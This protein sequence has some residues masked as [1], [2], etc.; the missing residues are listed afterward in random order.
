MPNGEHERHTGVI[1]SLYPDGNG[2]LI[3]PDRLNFDSLQFRVD[4]LQTTGVQRIDRFSEV[5]FYARKASKNAKNQ[6]DIARCITRRNG[7]LITAERRERG[8]DR[9]RLGAMYLPN[10]TK[11]RI[12]NEY[13]LNRELGYILD[14]NPNTLFGFILPFNSPHN[15][16]FVHIDDC[17]IFGKRI[18]RRYMEVEFVRIKDDTNEREKALHVSGKN[19]TILRPISE[20]HYLTGELT[21]NKLEL[22]DS[23]N[24]DLPRHKGQIVRVPSPI[25]TPQT[26]IIIKPNDMGYEPVIGFMGAVKSLNRK[27]LR[28]FDEVE[29]SVATNDKN[30]DENNN[31]LL[32]AYNITAGGNKPIIGAIRDLGRYLNSKINGETEL[33]KLDE[34]DI[35]QNGT[36]IKGFIASYNKFRKSGTIEIE[37]LQN[38]KRYRKCLFDIKDANLDSDTDTEIS[39]PLQGQ[40]IEFELIDND[41]PMLD[42]DGN[43]IENLPISKRAININSITT[44]NNIENIEKYL[45]MVIPDKKTDNNTINDDTNDDNNHSNKKMD[46][47]ED[48]REELLI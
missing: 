34:H 42:K 46:D 3:V 18:L 30:D 15:P 5:E 25:N 45:F 31:P 17:H 41:R 20:N 19:K 35:T 2:G 7:T 14:Y 29:F 10:D 21:T 40:K 27:D 33:L 12:P 44:T 32:T 39:V 47:I 37:C 1:V 8:S 16:L 13:G 43:V 23:N 26:Y 22:S 48:D 38:N 11:A 36:K 9:R 28:L 6:R 4:E 24:N